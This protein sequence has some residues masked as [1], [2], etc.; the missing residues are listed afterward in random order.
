M[1]EGA[2]GK[3]GAGETIVG[4]VEGEDAEDEGEEKFGL[5]VAGLG[6]VVEN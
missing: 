2:V 1:R 3:H 6:A 4:R 5:G